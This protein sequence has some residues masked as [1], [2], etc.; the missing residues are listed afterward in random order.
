MLNLKER[1]AL[2][3]KLICSIIST[4]IRFKEV[5][6]SSHNLS[7]L[8][9]NKGLRELYIAITKYFEAA[10]E[11][12]TFYLQLREYGDFARIWEDYNIQFTTETNRDAELILVDDYLKR[13]TIKIQKGIKDRNLKGLDYL[14]ALNSE[15]HTLLLSID[16]Q[17]SKKDIPNAEQ[18]D[19]LLKE[20]L[21]TKKGDSSKYIKTGF[22]MIDAKTNGIPKGHLTI[23]A[24]RP[25]Q[26]K[27]DFMLQLKRNILGEGYKVGVISLEMTFAE[28]QT[29][30]ISSL[31]KIDSRKIESGEIDKRDIA[32]IH[33]ESMKLKSDNYV[34]DDNSSQT[35]E[36][37][38]AT[39]RRWIMNKSV[40]LVFIDY[41]T[42][43]KTNF[44]RQRFD[45]EIG[46]LSQE[47]REFAKE[48]KLPIVLLSQLNRAVES[49]ND[50]K[51]YLSDLRESGSIEQDA[52]VVLFLHRPSYYGINPY[53]T[54]YEG[55]ELTCNNI[56][57][58]AVDLINVIIA[59]A[60]NGQ[61]GTVPLQY[62]PKYH[63]FDNIEI[64]A[65]LKK[66]S[67]SDYPW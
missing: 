51:P 17:Y 23:I 15:T 10:N 62:V 65:Q 26:G 37:I 57:V 5:Y 56:S 13:E 18:I 28:L 34:I 30:N 33:D 14:D 4:E 43:I 3:A 59:K 44:N 7:H 47:L 32:L 64:R 20:I 67:N 39:L 50:K 66:V 8:F 6:T 48:T 54:D 35:P 46:Q 49:R 24:G 58:D 31:S 2:E 61:T 1:N 55:M 45:L 27:T 25:G 36:S 29:R 63:A 38:K 42:L 16:K 22:R 60:R 11:L 9:I 40:D 52:N 21:D 53:K 19:K 12:P 41:L